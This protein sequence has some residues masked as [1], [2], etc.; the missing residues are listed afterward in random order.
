[1]CSTFCAL[2]EN[3]AEAHPQSVSSERGDETDV[4]LRSAGLFSLSPNANLPPATVEVRTAIPKANKAN[5]FLC[6]CR[7]IGPRAQP[8]AKRNTCSSTN[9]TQTFHNN[10][11]YTKKEHKKLQQTV[12][13]FYKLYKTLQH[14]SNKLPTLHQIA[15]HN[16]TKR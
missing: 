3:V 9:C 16:F 7:A 13:T 1:M 2:R 15:P 14:K 8:H 5:A 12:E 11:N 10:L 4:T 6:G